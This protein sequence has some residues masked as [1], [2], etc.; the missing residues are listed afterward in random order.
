MKG[1]V[2]NKEMKEKKLLQLL[3]QCKDG[4]SENDLFYNSMYCIRVSDTADKATKFWE[5]SL[6]GTMFL[7]KV[8]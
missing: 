5:L 3:A 4:P 2:L 6:N 1:S 8:F 7:Q